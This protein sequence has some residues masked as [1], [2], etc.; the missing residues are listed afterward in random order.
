M[1]VEWGLVK[2]EGEEE[3]S[4]AGIA[5]CVEPDPVLDLKALRS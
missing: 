1:S 3:E 5:L 4:Q 2:G